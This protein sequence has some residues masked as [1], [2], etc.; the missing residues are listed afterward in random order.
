MDDVTSGFNIGANVSLEAEF[1]EM[2]GFTEGEV[3][4]VLRMYR[5]RGAPSTRT[6]RPRL[7]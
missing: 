3:R 6:P 5:D 1:N 2:L 7:T 4:D